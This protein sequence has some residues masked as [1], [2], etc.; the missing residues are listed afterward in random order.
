M[1][2]SEEKK[3]NKL[4]DDFYYS[5]ERSKTFINR[6]KTTKERINN[7]FND[8]NLKSDYQIKLINYNKEFKDLNINDNSSDS[9]KKPKK[10]LIRNILNSAYTSKKNKKNFFNQSIENT[11]STNINGVLTPSS[12]LNSD[13]SKND[14]NEN[15]NNINITNDINCLSSKKNK[16][17]IEHFS[18]SK[19]NLNKNFIHIN[20]S[21]KKQNS[22]KIKNFPIF[23]IKIS[24]LIKGYNKIKKNSNK[25]KI[26]YL[27]NYF[28][29][30]EDID[31][32]KQTKEDLLMFLLKRKFLENKFPS[33]KIKTNSKRKEFLKKLTNDVEF[34]DKPDNIRLIEQNNSNEKIWTQYLKK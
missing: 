21:S 28:P 16:S 2:Y 26:N 4:F 12:N 7:L 27:K 22:N 14:I 15:I 34:L 33:K 32:M 5:N 10:N 24:D 8:K 13:K 18:L 11:N 29:S 9:E 3:Y 19:F 1:N 31:S 6:V 30:K 25:I 17:Y 20:N 23:T